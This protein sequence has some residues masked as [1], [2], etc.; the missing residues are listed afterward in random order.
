MA[1]KFP[2]DG[3]GCEPKYDASAKFTLADGG[4][5]V[6]SIAVAAITMFLLTSLSVLVSL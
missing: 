6:A 4:R 5:A 3:D 2:G 1:R